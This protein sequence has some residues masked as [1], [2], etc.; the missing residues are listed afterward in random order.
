MISSLKRRLSALAA[1]ALLPW[2]GHAAAQELPKEGL[3]SAGIGVVLL[4]LGPTQVFSKA[5]HASGLRLSAGA[6]LDLGPRWALRLPL[7]IAASDGSHGGGAELALSPGLVYRFRYRAQQGLVPY[8]GAGVELGMFGADRRI[9]GKPL[10]PVPHTDVSALLHEHPHNASDPNFDTVGTVGGVAWAGASL[11]A[12]QLVSVDFEL[13]GEA[14]AI[15][16]VVV[17][18]IAESVALHLTF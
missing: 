10:L 3:F 13:A 18:A 1:A 6:Q 15:D 5:G 2:C 12:S 9:L 17:E 7:V 16:G 4:S 11:H 14:V 8:L